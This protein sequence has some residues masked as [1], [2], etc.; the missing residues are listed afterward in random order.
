VRHFPGGKALKHLA[1][2]GDQRSAGLL[3]AETGGKIGYGNKEK[4]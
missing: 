2:G 3:S 4:L 1:E